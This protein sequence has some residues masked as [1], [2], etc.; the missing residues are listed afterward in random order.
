VSTIET[1]RMSMIDEGKG[2]RIWNSRK[3][4]VG[5]TSV[6]LA[7]ALGVGAVIWP[8][9]GDEALRPRGA[10]ANVP[11][12]QQRSKP[13]KADDL[14][15]QIVSSTIWPMPKL[16]GKGLPEI[17]LVSGRSPV[18]FELQVTNRGKHAIRILHVVGKP[19][20]KAADG[21]EFK[22]QGG[23]ADRECGP[24]VVNLEAGKTVTANRFAYLYMGK[25][26]PMS[27]AWMDEY[28]EGWGIEDLK[29]SKY[30]L[31]LHYNTR[32]GR[33][34]SFI[35]WA[36]QSGVWMGDVQTAEVPV[37]IV[38]LK[39]S[40][41]VVVDGTEAMFRPDGTWEV[42]KAE[43]RG[44]KDPVEI[45]ALAD[46]VW[47]A[48]AAGKETQVCLGFRIAAVEKWRVRIIPNL[49]T[50]RINSADGAECRARKTGATVP[51]DAPQYLELDSEFSQ[52]V[53]YPATLFRADK[54]LT[55]AWADGAGN[56][57]HIEN[58]QPG[59]YSVGYVIRADKGPPERQNSYWVGELQT[60][61]VQ[62][63][64]KE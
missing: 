43:E 23:G 38:D 62:I 42:V 47:K 30:L 22:M 51:V 17:K 26:G 24:T 34:N 13:V 27:L 16:I 55:L 63:D 33:D 29:P 11:V 48:P 15:F 56:V 8:K 25:P 57:W 10:E 40:R 54:S 39:A 41:P 6:L 64:I 9:A 14:E 1:Q 12:I 28:C 61:A 19:I 2:M 44:W 60:A 49:A 37:E 58:L 53:A 36:G 50:V 20:L 52:S 21:K 5:I 45:M 18:Q 59:R 31:R 35:T 3:K 46:T 7:G 4:T 32:H